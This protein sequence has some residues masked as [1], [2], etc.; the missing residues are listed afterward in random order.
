VTFSE[1]D[2]TVDFLNVAQFSSFYARFLHNNLFSVTVV[3]ESA[4]LVRYVNY[5]YD[6]G[7][8][9]TMT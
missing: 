1:C 6:Y 4:V 9:K 8:V 7:S 2:R 5:V 3:I